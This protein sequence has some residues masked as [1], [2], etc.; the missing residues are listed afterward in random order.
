VLWLWTTID[1]LYSYALVLTGNH[2]EAEDLVQE[3]HVR[4]MQA[5]ASL[6]ADSNIKCWLFAI[7]KNIAR[8]QLRKGRNG[9][10]TSEVDLE[11]DI[12]SSMAKPSGD[13]RDLHASKMEIEHVRAAIQELPVEL[14]EV[15]LLREHAEFS[16]REIA[17]VLDCPIGTVMSRLRRAR[18]NLYPLLALRT[19]KQPAQ[20]TQNEKAEIPG[21]E[22]CSEDSCPESTRFENLDRGD[23]QEGWT[24]GTLLVSVLVP[25]LARATTFIAYFCTF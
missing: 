2:A 25:L 4:A 22:P 19:K 20:V 14:R 9:L 24:V 3:T 11:T 12:A 10:Q 23:A 13:S 1:G 8:N 17:S 7:L 6:R 18:E 15:I 5:T 16:Y 21:T